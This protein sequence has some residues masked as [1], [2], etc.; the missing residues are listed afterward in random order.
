MQNLTRWPEGP[1]HNSVAPVVITFKEES[2]R[3]EI[4]NVCREGLKKTNLVITE[5]SK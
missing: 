2:E 4:Y 3:N 1:E 5:D